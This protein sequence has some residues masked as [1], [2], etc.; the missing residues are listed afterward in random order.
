MDTDFLV[1]GGGSSGCVLATRLAMANVGTVTLMEAGGRDWNPLF[2]WPAG[3]ARMTKGMASWGWETVPQKSM[4]DR[5]LWYTQAK[6]LGGGSSI[7][8]Q[9]YN[10]GNARDFDTWAHDFGCDGWDYDNVLPYFTRSERNEVFGGHFHGTDGFLGVSNPRG[11]LPICDAFIRAG[12]EYGLPYNPDF[13]GA[14]QYGVGYYQLTQWAGR[15]SSTSNAYLPTVSGSD[16]L[17]VLTNSVA[18]RIVTR[19]ERAVSVDYICDNKPHHI[20]INGEIIISSGAIGSPCLLMRSGIG[21]SSHLRSHDIDVVT[22]LPSVGEN[23]QDHLDLCTI[24]EC[25]GRHTYDGMDRLDRTLLTGLR[26]LL[27]G[28]GAVTSSL[29]E[30]GGFGCVNSDSSYPDV[31]FH[32]GQGSGIEK[33]IARISGYGVT[34]NS[35][36]LRPRSRGSVRLSGSDITSP[37]LIDPNYWS[38]S[39]D[40]DASLSCLEVAREI[41]GQRSL[42]G[43]VR[44]E[45][46]P[47]PDITTPSDMYSYACR[48]AKT[49][50]HPVGTCRMGGDAASVVTPDLLVRGFTNLR[51]CD[52]SVMPTLVSAN[53]NAA[54]IMISERGSDLVLGR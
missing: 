7:N 2:H 46:L 29:F 13:N 44:G 31:Q 22:D 37:P 14:S 4:N 36:Y 26:Y 27:F 25:T 43:F 33:G 1:I 51:V 24:W 38:D 41:M 15:R 42:S 48:V 21:P 3:F 23:L 12:Q 17:R 20:N 19:G 8:A 47:G 40:L 35:A 34:L 39:H 45:I 28:S 16:N 5:V 10:R 32:L 52:S 53:T 54:T 6:V 9:L 49:D 50:H 11:A 30:T 18:T